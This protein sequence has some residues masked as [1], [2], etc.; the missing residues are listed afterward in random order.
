MRSR[1]RRPRSRR[2]HRRTAWRAFR[3]RLWAG[4]RRPRLR[5]SARAALRRWSWLGACAILALAAF[6]A[7][8]HGRTGPRPVPAAIP[9]LGRTALWLG[10]VQR[11]AAPYGVPAALELGLIAHE[12][13]GDY[14]ALDR[15]A[16]GTV[17]AGLAQ[18]NS[19]P[20]PADAH[21]AEYG[22]LQNPDDPSANVA[23]SLRILSADVG[24]YG[25]V[26]DG[27]LAYNA[28]TPRRG[29][30][31]DP[32]YPGDVLAY[33]R[34]IEA[35]PVVAAW[36]AGPGW[37][38]GGAAWAGPASSAGHPVYVVVAA[39]APA[40]GLQAYGGASWHGIAG[41]AAVSVRAGGRWIAGWPS[42]LA[43]PG[44]RAAMPPDAAYWWAPLEVA[45]G[46]G[47]DVE[48]EAE[49]AGAPPA[50]AARTGTGT[51]SA[52]TRLVL[53]AAAAPGA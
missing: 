5:R 8:Q 13:H 48:V 20:P 24:R 40:A 37:T 19:G 46:Q 50:G 28:G 34:Q 4:R 53:R 26:R 47:L 31:Y 44:L 21:W 39:M 22:L 7:W 25:D 36:P 23:A 15:D 35:G 10:L 6:A 27:L 9:V 16:N 41:P 30:L 3:P 29:L 49:W 38:A 2:R 32:G 33:A 11:S 52:W 43:P 1:T 18:I 51:V 42:I 45:P 14:L 12:S 17:D